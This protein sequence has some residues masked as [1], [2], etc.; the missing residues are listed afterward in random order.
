[1]SI[2]S[3]DSFSEQ[4]QKLPLQNPPKGLLLDVQS[5]IQRRKAFKQKATQC[6]VVLSLFVAT[7]WVVVDQQSNFKSDTS[8]AENEVHEAGNL[9]EEENE[10][11][12]ANNLATLHQPPPLTLTAIVMRITDIDQEI[13][14][15]S[16]SDTEHRQELLDELLDTHSTLKESYRTI[17]L[18][19]L[20]TAYQ[21]DAYLN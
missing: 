11:L 16:E 3:F 10:Q 15:L 19:Q 6:G 7:L 8:V 13:K 9:T 12:F 1:M 5:T 20:A 18:H 14:Q 4:L 2:S 21:K 17:R